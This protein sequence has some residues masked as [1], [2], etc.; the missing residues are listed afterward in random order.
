M[1][2][3]LKISSQRFSCLIVSERGR[4]VGGGGGYINLA[5]WDASWMAGD[6]RIGGGTGEL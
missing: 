5:C 4:T 2:E 3:R 6:D 1:Q